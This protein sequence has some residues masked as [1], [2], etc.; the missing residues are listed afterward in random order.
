[1]HSV[2]PF[3]AYATKDGGRRSGVLAKRV[4]QTPVPRFQ[5]L[6]QDV[7]GSGAAVYDGRAVEGPGVLHR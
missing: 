1:M 7:I 5:R 2:Q 4:S 6:I 3:V